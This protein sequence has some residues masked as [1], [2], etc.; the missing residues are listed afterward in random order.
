MIEIY[1]GGA[2]QWV[3]L[4]KE[5][6]IKCIILSNSNKVDKVTKVALDLDLP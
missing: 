3:D 5:N 4:I 6:N 1:F 2:K